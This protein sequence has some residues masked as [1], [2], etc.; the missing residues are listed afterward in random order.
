[1]RD[2]SKKLV[3][4]LEDKIRV[5]IYA[6]GRTASHALASH[7]TAYSVEPAS[8]SYLCA[9]RLAMHPQWCSEGET[10]ANLVPLYILLTRASAISLQVT[11]T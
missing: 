9:V 2:F 8:V 11:V 7:Y 6:G 5:M 4:L 10:T 1:M 3:P